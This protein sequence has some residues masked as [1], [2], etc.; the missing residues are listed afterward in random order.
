[1]RSRKVGAGSGD[2]EV[3]GVLVVD[4]DEATVRT[5]LRLLKQQGYFAMGFT[6]AA[7]ILERNAADPYQ[8][9]ILDIALDQ[10]QSGIEVGELLRD[11]GFDGQIIA[12]SG[13]TDREVKAAALRR[14]ADQFVMKGDGPEVLIASVASAARHC[15]AQLALPLL[16]VLAEEKAVRVRGRGIWLADQEYAFLRALD[17][18]RNQVIPHEELDPILG[19]ERGA[20]YAL[21]SRVQRRLGPAG[22]LI[23]NVEGKGYSLLG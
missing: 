4:D 16:E 9:L 20:R 10:G 11:R 2:D 23:I 7:E 13:T 12:L 17:A 5:T 18:K 19:K 14:A 3:I 22:T 21:K 6:T 1:M 15:G 8:I